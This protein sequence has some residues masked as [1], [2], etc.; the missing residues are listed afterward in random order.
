MYRS[1]ILKGFVVIAMFTM[2]HTMLVGCSSEH[3][4]PNDSVNRDSQ[5]AS[6]VQYYTDQPD[7]SELAVFLQ[8]DSVD[9]EVMTESGSVG[10]C[11]VR[12]DEVSGSM[13]VAYSYTASGKAGVERILAMSGNSSSDGAIVTTVDRAWTLRT[14]I[15]VV[16][17]P[18]D[19]MAYT[20]TEWTESDTL[21]IHR[22]LDGERMF[23]TYLY[24]GSSFTVNYT[25]AEMNNYLV[26]ADRVSNPVA[27]VDT[28]KIP[29]ALDRL[30][31]AALAFESFYVEA[32]TLE[33]NLDGEVLV[34][35]MSDP[36]FQSWLELR[37][38][39]SGLI[40]ADKLSVETLCEIAGLASY[41]CWLPPYFGNFICAAAAGVGVAC[42]IYS[43][44]KWLS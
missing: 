23:E 25:E 27:N 33:H 44:W 28:V 7:L 13:V 11:D 43:V 17:D 36:D 4:I 30:D 3:S 32:G 34:T 26:N 29:S 6:N 31:A 38:G 18:A 21:A 12:V 24:R 42:T 2:I 19:S 16:Q 39:R 14:G 22:K 20:L 10:L 35:L 1:T 41:K 15:S 9:L 37:T 40:D 5:V 8:F